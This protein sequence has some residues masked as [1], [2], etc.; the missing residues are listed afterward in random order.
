MT[1][2][3][4]CPGLA[5]MALL[6]MGGFLCGAGPAHAQEAKQEVEGAPAEAPQEYVYR[7]AAGDRIELRFTYNP[8]LNVEQT[9]RPDG[10]IA[11]EH[12]GEVEAAGLTPL[13]LTTELESRFGRVLKH[14]KITVV[15]RDFAGRRVYVG[16][17][18]A[19]PG[20]IEL[21]GRMTVLEAILNSGG[22]KTSASMKS[23]VLL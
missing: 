7:L 23:V 9:I 4:G 3:N 13:E 10:R 14:A 20:V 5:R 16:G 2:E 12:V 1:R 15:V 17:E 6:V 11:L 19:T 18:V 8:E 22:A 21:Q